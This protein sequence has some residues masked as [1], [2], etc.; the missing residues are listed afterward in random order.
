M[1]CLKI[2]LFLVFGIVVLFSKSTCYAQSDIEEDVR[3]QIEILTSGSK[4][5]RINAANNLGEM[6]E[7]AI[8]A[9]PFLINILDEHRG[10]TRH[11]KKDGINIIIEVPSPAEVAKNALVKI[12]QPTVV[13]L[14]EALQNENLKGSIRQYVA[15][16]LGELKDLRALE[17]LHYALKQNRVPYPEE[18]S[19]KE[20]AAEALCMMKDP[21]SIK[22][23]IDE[24]A[25]A[26][27][28][29]T[30]KISDMLLEM[31]ETVIETLIAELSDKDKTSGHKVRIIEV[32]DKIESPRSIEPLMEVLLNI[33]ESSEVRAEAADVLG[34]MGDSRA[35]EPLITALSDESEN[36]EPLKENAV[37]ALGRLKDPR[38]VEPLI[39][40]LS[41]KDVSFYGCSLKERIVE[42][43]G[44]MKDP[45]AV[46]SLIILMNDKNHE[47]NYEKHFYVKFKTNTGIFKALTQ[48]TGEKNGRDR[49]RWNRWWNKNKSTYLKR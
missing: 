33:D 41:I 21:R 9:I 27:L 38:A 23:L 43:L 28:F 24:I 5:E 40:T 20:G 22:P 4:L 19:I 34:K 14:I 29:I 3:V 16:A 15:K 1:K 26:D 8:P 18:R 31:G 45:R 37:V 47:K 35:V 2:Y 46:E 6:G 44:E 12:G 48:I 49:T 30:E 13:P 39:T 10:L 11:A 36:N 42:V 17:P 32:L 25:C 7:R